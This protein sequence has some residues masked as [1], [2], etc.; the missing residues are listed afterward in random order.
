[1]N[2]LQRDVD[3]LKTTLKSSTS[4]GRLYYQTLPKQLVEKYEQYL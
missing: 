3:I 2:D 4:N 1:M